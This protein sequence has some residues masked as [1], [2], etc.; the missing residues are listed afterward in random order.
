MRHTHR[1]RG[2]FLIAFRHAFSGLW[3]A[4]RTQRNARIHAAATLLVLGLAGWL[5]LQPMGWAL[6]I[7]AIGLV[8]TA[9]LLNTSLE[10]LMDL[11]TPDLHPLVRT[12]KDVAAAAVLVASAAAAV[13]GFLILGPPLWQRLSGA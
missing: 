5:G 6:L 3:E 11:A 4:I 1:K 9:E 13:I 7:V 10:A 8:W 12:S 2:F